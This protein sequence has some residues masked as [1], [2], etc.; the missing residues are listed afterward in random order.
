MLPPLPAPGSGFKGNTNTGTNETIH[1]ISQMMR[2]NLRYAGA[3]QGG[4]TGYVP[5][6]GC[7]RSCVCRANT[8]R[9]GLRGA[10]QCPLTHA[11]ALTHTALVGVHRAC[12]CPALPCTCSGGTVPRPTESSPHN[13][14]PSP[15]LSIATTPPHTQQHAPRQGRQQRGGRWPGRRPWRAAAAAAPVLS[16]V[17]HVEGCEH[18]T[19]DEPGRYGRHGHGPRRV[20]GGPGDG[21]VGA[22]QGAFRDGG[23]WWKR[24]GEDVCTPGR[25]RAA[26]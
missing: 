21:Y 20:R 14:F 7:V 18:R 11:R 9:V 6:C 15:P 4:N 5:P 16:S 8:F 19:G 10:G 24:G 26:K 25:E 3:G 2:P 13:A 1:D 12:C 23:G 17:W 22:A